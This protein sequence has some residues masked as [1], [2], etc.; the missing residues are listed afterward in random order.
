MFG[1]A[2]PS[3]LQPGSRIVAQMGPYYCKRLEVT[4]AKF[5]PG[6]KPEPSCATG[7]PSAWQGAGDPTPCHHPGVGSAPAET[8]EPCGSAGEAGGCRDGW[9]GLAKHG[10]FGRR[11]V[12]LG[13]GGD[14]IS[15]THRVMSWERQRGAAR[16]AAL[17]ESSPACPPGPSSGQ[18]PSAG[19]VSPTGGEGF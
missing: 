18:G 19:L 4:L 16:G 17:M 15:S 7:A 12:C 13:R 8:P 3:P 2:E 6:D 5:L 9:P 14:V 10:V 11:R 1:I